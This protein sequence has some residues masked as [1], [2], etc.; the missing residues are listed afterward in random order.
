MF[1]ECIGIWIVHEWKKMGKVQ[2]LQIVELGPG[3]GT[4]MKDI[5]K[6]IYKL[7]PEE[8]KHLQIHLVETSPNLTKI[9]QTSI[10]SCQW[11]S[12]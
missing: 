8:M 5:L 2:P 9:Q 12:I 4:L 11:L 3:N 7:T 1:G 6:T 10:V